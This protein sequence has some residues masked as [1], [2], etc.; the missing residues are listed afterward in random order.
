MNTTDFRSTGLLSSRIQQ[1]H[2]G[3][4]EFQ[5]SGPAAGGSL[6]WVS[7]AERWGAITAKQ[8]VDETV[9][10][11]VG[12]DQDKTPRAFV[13]DSGLQPKYGVVR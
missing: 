2:R 8:A 11:G 6:I 5:F 1:I 4:R 7:D 12:T 9:V 13:F 10:F 3:P